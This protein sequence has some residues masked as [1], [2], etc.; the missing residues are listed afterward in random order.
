MKAQQTMT[1]ALLKYR[2]S[3]L[4]VFTPNALH[5]SLPPLVVGSY[6]CMGGDTIMIAM[7]SI[8]KRAA[9]IYDLLGDKSNDMDY[10]RRRVLAH[11][12][13]IQHMDIRLDVRNGRAKWLKANKLEDECGRPRGPKSMATKEGRVKYVRE[14]LK[15]EWVALGVYVEGSSAET[16]IE[17]N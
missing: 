5:P 8:V 7:P 6:I 2:L 17:V 13:L 11:Q 10:L 1:A 4:D 15:K 9:H 12:R 14:G 3:K 16:A